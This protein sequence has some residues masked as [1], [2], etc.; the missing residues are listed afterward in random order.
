MFMRLCLA[1][2]YGLGMGSTQES[3]Q[4]SFAVC[5]LVQALLECYG[6]SVGGD[7]PQTANQGQDVAV[8]INER[9]LKDVPDMKFI[10]NLP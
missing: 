3:S 4:N 1:I 7:N 6:S 5:F 10:L 8:E 9:I 2:G